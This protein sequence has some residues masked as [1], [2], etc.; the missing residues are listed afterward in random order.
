MLGAADGWVS[1]DSSGIEK[2]YHGGTE[3]TE[4]RETGKGHDF[5]LSMEPL[6]D[7][8]FSR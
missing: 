7:V 4:E 5:G 6:H 3:G 1:G 2:F 8:E